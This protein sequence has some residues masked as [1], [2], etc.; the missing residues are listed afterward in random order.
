MLAS[1]AKRPAPYGRANLRIAVPPT[2]RVRFHLP[3]EA[4]NVVDQNI[5]C[6]RQQKIKPLWEN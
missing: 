3:D 2:I 1:I 6:G 4:A 5:E